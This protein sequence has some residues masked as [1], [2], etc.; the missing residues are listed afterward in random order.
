[1]VEALSLAVADR[2]VGEQRRIAAPAGVEQSALAAHVEEGL[3]LA[4]E[5]RLRQILR[6]GAGAH[7]DADLVLAATA[8]QLAIAFPDRLR[9]RLR[10]LGVEEEPADRLAGL[11]Q[12]SL[13]ALQRPDAR[14]QLFF[15]PVGRDVFAE[16]R[17]SRG[18]P[19]RHAHAL[20]LQGAHHLAERGVLAADTRHVVNG[21]GLEPGYALFRHRCAPRVQGQCRSRPAD[22]LL[23]AYRRGAAIRT[24]R[25]RLRSRKLAGCR[26][27][28]ERRGGRRDIT[29]PYQSRRF[30]GNPLPDSQRPATTWKLLLGRGTPS[31]RL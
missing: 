26:R 9:V 22:G 27:V 4:G 31:T 14:A 16:G 7:G 10:E 17:R 13:A 29:A 19:V 11:V 21:Q 15:D 3:R 5:A 12:R 23:P 1:M 18:E 8:R 28:W 6:G 30:F 20:V 25:P 24:P 2:A